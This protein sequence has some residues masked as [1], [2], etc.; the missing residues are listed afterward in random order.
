MDDTGDGKGAIT[1][2][3]Q[4]REVTA[5]EFRKSIRTI[6]RW[7][8]MGLPVICVGAVRMHDPVSVRRWLEGRE[9]RHDA[10]G[11]GRPK[12]AR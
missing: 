5:A 12:G 11:R 8:R 9:R 10:P 6:S 3:L 4:L 2:G 7:E 1:R